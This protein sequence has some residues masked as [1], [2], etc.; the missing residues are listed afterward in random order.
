MKKI[1]S[2]VLVFVLLVGT[3]FTLASCAELGVVLGTYESGITT[4]EF[5]IGKVTV[6]ESVEFLG[7]VTSKTYECKYKIEN[8]DDGK[9]ITFIYEDGADEHYVF[10]GTKTFSVGTE[11]GIDYIKIGYVTYDKK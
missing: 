3:V 11:D 8:T 4:A 2:S 9:T 1:I 5:S 7:T 6:T 10:N